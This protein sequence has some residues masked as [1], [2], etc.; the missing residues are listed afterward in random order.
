MTNT[1]L[2]VIN[3]WEVPTKEER[4]TILNYSHELDRWYI[5]TDVPKHARKYEK[6]LDENEPH[7][8]GYS[9]AGNLSMIEGYIASANVTI[10]KKRI[11]N[12]TDEQKQ[13]ASER[14]KEVRKK[15]LS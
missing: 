9:D 5:Y 7:R 8:K 3:N 4:E 15:Q 1:N 14:M 13:R 10:S 2:T 6:Y 11:S 12:M